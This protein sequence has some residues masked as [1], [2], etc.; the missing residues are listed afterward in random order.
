M[1]ATEIAFT[2]PTSGIVS[3]VTVAV[4]GTANGIA[5]VGIRVFDALNHEGYVFVYTGGN[6]GTASAIFQACSF[7]RGQII[8]SYSKTITKIN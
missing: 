2:H 1:P 3:I 8:G 7:P 5:Y 6:S 4:T